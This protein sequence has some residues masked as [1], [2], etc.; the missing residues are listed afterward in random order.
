MFDI[1]VIKNKDTPE[2]PRN[3]NVFGL[4]QINFSEK[5]MRRMLHGATS[6]IISTTILDAD[7]QTIPQKGE[8]YYIA[9]PFVRKY[10]YK[11]DMK[12]LYSITYCADRQE[13]IFDF[14]ITHIEQIGEKFQPEAMQEFEARFFIKI[15]RCWYRMLKNI[16]LSKT[17][18][19]N[20]YNSRK[21]D[22]VLVIDFE[23]ITPEQV[24]EEMGKRFMESIF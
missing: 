16:K 3:C 22:S 24:R 17:A 20:L 5:M 23:I 1:H 12:T 9:E 4:K 15:K 19:R 11:W 14:G 21:S 6:A 10:G 8:I 13:K 2:I 18:H 7:D